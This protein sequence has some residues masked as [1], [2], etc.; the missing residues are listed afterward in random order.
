LSFTS[1]FARYF[2]FSTPLFFRPRAVR[3]TAV[4]FSASRCHVIHLCHLSWSE[5]DP[6]TTRRIHPTVTNSFSPKIED[7]SGLGVRPYRDGVRQ[8]R[9][10]SLSGI[11]RLVPC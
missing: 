6:P 9:R 11:V 2:H 1:S 10:L 3:P 7:L 5:Q 4:V 8:F